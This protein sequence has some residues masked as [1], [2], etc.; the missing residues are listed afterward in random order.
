MLGGKNCRSNFSLSAVL[1][2]HLHL[3]FHDAFCLFICQ[4]ANLTK[5]VNAAEQNLKSCHL[6]SISTCVVLS[7][8][9]IR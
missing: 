2:L 9:Q 5:E 8:L 3:C 7:F 1:R 4:V 6:D